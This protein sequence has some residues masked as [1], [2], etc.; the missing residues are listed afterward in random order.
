MLLFAV[1]V[2]FQIENN[3]ASHAMRLDAQHFAEKWLMRAC[4]TR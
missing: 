2:C 3:A 4:E 1:T